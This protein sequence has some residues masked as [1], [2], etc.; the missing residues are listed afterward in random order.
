[1]QLTR[2]RQER[3]PSSPTFV[4]M[5]MWVRICASS[6]SG[7]F[8]I[9]IMKLVRHF[10]LMYMPL[11]LELRARIL[12]GTDAT[13]GKEGMFLPVARGLRLRARRPHPLRPW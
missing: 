1:V 10:I 9:M 12:L 6:A 4:Y 13:I 11:T 3:T 8:V 5:P 2:D 7:T